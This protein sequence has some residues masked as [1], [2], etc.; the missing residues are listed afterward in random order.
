MDSTVIIVVGVVLGILLLA[1]IGVLFFL[2]SKTKNP[3][4]N[5]QPIDLQKLIESENLKMQLKLVEQNNNSILELQKIK[6]EMVLSVQK[7]VSNIN[8]RVEKRLGDGFK[9][10]NETFKGV[11]ERLA[12]IDEAQKNMDRISKDI[13]SLQ[14]VLTDKSSRGA[15]GETQLTQ[16]LHA[17]YGEKN[18]K[19]FQE[20][21]SFSNKKRADAV[22]FA[23]EPLGKVA[24]DS[25]FPLENFRNINAEEI[26]KEEKEKN[27]K[28]FSGDLKKH[29]DD[30]SSKYIIPGETSEHA[31]MF[32]PSEAVFSEVVAYHEKQIEYASS[33]SVWITSPTT[34]MASLSLIQSMV[35]NIEQSKYA[36]IIQSQL[37][38]L[39]EEFMRFEDRFNTLESRFDQANKS[40]REINITTKKLIKR[41][42]EIEQVEKGED[43][44]DDN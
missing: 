42:K 6:E 17:I 1:V 24:I 18:D 5:T 36:D 38:S 9:E 32:L 12:K 11:I 2:I 8:E 10:S 25:K 7:E 37:I 41:F 28:L 19:L 40:F 3:I 35:K 20:Q 23:P 39:G 44:E 13:L 4:E 33:K 22:I 30:I 29:I 43:D 14:S 21:Y 16:I 34:L 31:I 27:R 15:F 26:T